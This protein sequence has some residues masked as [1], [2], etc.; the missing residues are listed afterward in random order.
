AGESTAGSGKD[1]GE[2]Y[3]ELTAEFGTANYTRIDAPATPEQKTRL[4]KLSPEAVATDELAGEPIT[5]KFTVAPGDGASIGGLKV[6]TAPGLF[7]APPS[8][9]GGIYKIYAERF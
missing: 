7:A 1:P 9:T 6:T 2:H 3:Q 8:G 4:A 5:A